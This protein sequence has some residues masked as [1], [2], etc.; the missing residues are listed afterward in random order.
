MSLGTTSEQKNSGTSAPS[1]NDQTGSSSESSMSFMRWRARLNALSTPRAVLAGI[2]ALVVSIGLQIRPIAPEDYRS[3]TG[4]LKTMMDHAASQRVLLWSIAF[5]A[6][7]AVAYACL[8]RWKESGTRERVWAAVCAAL[9]SWTIVIPQTASQSQ[10]YS[11]YPVFAPDRAAW[12]SKRL[13]VLTVAKWLCFGAFLFVVLVCLFVLIAGSSAMSDAELAQG[14]RRGRFLSRL[15]LKPGPV[16]GLS[17]IIFACWTPIMVAN[18]PFGI[19]VDTM[20]QLI[21]VSGYPAWDQAMMYWLP[22]YWMSDHNPFA[23]SLL[24]GAF[25]KIGDGLFHSEVIGLFLLMLVQSYVCAL[26][27]SCVVCWIAERTAA[28]RFLLSGILLLICFVPS[29]SS[30]MTQIIKDSTWLPLYLFWIVCFAEYAYRIL[31]DK[32]LPWWLVTLL[33]VSAIFAGLSK[34]S[35]TAMTFGAT[36]MLIFLPRCRWKTMIAAF[37]P[38]LVVLMVVPATL[39]GPLR[40]APGGKQEALMVPIAEVSKVF[41]DHG[42]EIPRSDWEAVNRTID[43]RKARKLWIPEDADPPKVTF[44]RKTA[45]SSDI[46][47]FLVEWAKL[48]LKYPMSYLLATPYTWDSFAFGR[49]Y[50]TVGPVKIGWWWS[51][52]EHIMPGLPDGYMSPVQKK[53]GEPLQTFLNTVPPFSL[54]GDQALYCAWIPL[55]AAMACVMRRRYRQLVFFWPAVM[56]LIVQICL[57]PA[58]QV[59]YSL[60]LLALFPLELA[61][62]LIPALPRRSRTKRAAQEIQEKAQSTEQTASVE[63]E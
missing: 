31:N 46:R 25:L 41:K 63:S 28:G 2:L 47:L 51:G 42:S 24:Y 58:P 32:P 4:L 55:L 8:G 33:T 16:F 39:F 14:S 54:L 3:G 17:G 1:T 62:A 22:G 11:G 53:I 30:Y 60:G 36:F 38:P 5:L 44:R 12:S 34:K 61:A 9:L 43:I 57:I 10:P 19:G 37:V 7:A 59:R 45:T 52:G 20:T 40:I 21:Q 56:N 27:L 18:G 13:I 23:D 49:A 48:G 29:F 50:Y 26:A 15:H 6:L 35:S